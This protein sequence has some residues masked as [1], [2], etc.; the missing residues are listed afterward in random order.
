MSPAVD[1]VIPVYRE[2]DAILEILDHL[3]ATVKTRFRALIC[4]DME[5]DPTLA[6][7]K[8]FTH[9]SFELIPVKNE[10]KGV[11]GAIMTGFKKSEAA[12]VI[13][14]PADDNRNGVIIDELVRQFE[15]GCDLVAPSRFMKG[16]CMKGCRF[17][18]AALVRTAAFLLHHIARVPTHD[19][20][21]GFRL[22][23]RRVLSLI[24]VESTE[25]FAFSIEYLV[26]AHRL[27]LK[28]G[29][30]PASWFERK[31]GKSRFK[32][33]RWAPIY[34]RWFFYAFATT[35]FCLRST[36]NVACKASC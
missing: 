4:Y 24:K 2:G 11:H 16:G 32:I 26:K 25:G 5:E 28:I 10:G 3:R 12:A 22:F 33:L 31:H 29:E 21:N 15:A 35:V 36:R 23:S 19:P 30:V 7:L 34:L 14:Y 27:G 18:K 20:T 6:A 17:A 8:R 1:L 13:V 9:Q